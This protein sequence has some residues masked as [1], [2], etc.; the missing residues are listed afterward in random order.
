[1]KIGFVGLGKMGANMSLRLAIGSPD[2]SVKGGHEIVGF[3]KDPNPDLVGV[4][5]IELVPSVEQL[6][7]RL[8]HPKVIWVMVPA[9]NAT[10]QVITDLAQRLG[11]GDVIIDGGNSYYKDSM[12]RAQ[13]LAARK[14]RFLDIGTSGGIWGRREG[15][16]MMVG[17]DSQTVSLIEPIL[18]TLAPRNGWAHV[19][20]NGAGHFVKMV[21][22]GCEYGLMEA[23]G[24]AFEVLY[25]SKFDLNLHQIAQVWNRG[26]VIRSWL[27]ELAEKMLE[28]QPTLSGVLPYVEDSGEGRW[29]LMAA[30]EE[31]VSL[32]VISAALFSRFASR[33][34]YNL[35]ARF[36]AALRNQFG[37][38]EIKKAGHTQIEEGGEVH[39]PKAQS[40]TAGTG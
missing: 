23:Y 39:E 36:I 11:E 28:T 4:K 15:Y 31:D 27:L 5:G 16:C 38:H 10:E 22:N 25:K 20:P 33:D 3:A 34:P 7:G 18:E 1:M 12:R 37:G 6:V 40:Q 19:G 32:P 26:S 14:I 8:P 9:G 17:G 2:G 21:H 30:I 29:T 24:E 13:G 35:S